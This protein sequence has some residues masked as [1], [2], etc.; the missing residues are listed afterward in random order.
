MNFYEFIS[1]ICLGMYT[2]YKHK[3]HRNN[4]FIFIVI[5]LIFDMDNSKS[6]ELEVVLNIINRN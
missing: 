5:F 1:M 4:Y 6:I 2:D 3:V